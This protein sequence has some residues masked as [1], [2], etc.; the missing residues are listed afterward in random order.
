MTWPWP[1]PDSPLGLWILEVLKQ[2]VLVTQVCESCCCGAMD[3]DVPSSSKWAGLR[4]H[5]VA[6]EPIFPTQ[7]MFNRPET[8]WAVNCSNP[9]WIKHK[10]PAALLLPAH[11]SYHCFL[12]NVCVSHVNISSS[13][14]WTRPKTAVSLL[15]PV[16]TAT[17]GCGP[18]AELHWARSEPPSSCSST[19]LPAASFTCR[20]SGTSAKPQSSFLKNQ[21]INKFVIFSFWWLVMSRIMEGLIR[22]R[23]VWQDAHSV[24][25]LLW[26]L[27]LTLT[28]LQI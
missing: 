20:C 15:D 28:C 24:S 11:F 6:A 12:F 1:R 18:W 27:F 7:S 10:W 25:L 9:G 4:S 13:F 17:G 21:S 19:K 3:P 14:S 8:V 2:E 5:P 22:L 26:H 23:T 16:P